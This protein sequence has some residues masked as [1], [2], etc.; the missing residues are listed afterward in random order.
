MNDPYNHVVA[1]ISE[2]LRKNPEASRFITAYGQYVEHI[3]DMVDEDK[4]V[5]LIDK[6]SFLASQIFSSNYWLKNAH[7]LLIVEQLIH[8]IYFNTL[9]WE[10]AEELWKR[11]DAKAMSHCG[12]YMLFAVLLLE[13]QDPALVQKISLGFMERCHV[14]HLND[15]SYQELTA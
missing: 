7:Y 3:D 8:I 1:E 11:R 14:Y 12:Y 5:E 6:S 13:T 4:E 15:L 9:K 2:I 10:K